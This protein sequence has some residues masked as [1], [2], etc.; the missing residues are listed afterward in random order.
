MIVGPS[1]RFFAMAASNVMSENG[2][3]RVR[4][5]GL[6]TVYIASGF[7]LARVLWGPARGRVVGWG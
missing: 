1:T 4:P 6:T 3:L 7:A 5:P 2:F